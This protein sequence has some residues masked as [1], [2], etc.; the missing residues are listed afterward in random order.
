ME[1]TSA[2]SFIQRVCH[3]LLASAQN[4][5][6]GWGFHPASESRVEPASWALLGL[7]NSHSFQ[8]KEE[9]IARGLRFIRSTQLPDGSWPSTPG[10]KAG[11]WVTS[12]ACWALS[13]D[14]SAADPAAAGLNW[15]CNDWPRDSSRWSRLLRRLSPGRERLPHNDSYRGWG[16]TTRTSSWVEPTSFAL[17]ALRSAA[18]GRLPNRA[19]RRRL[20]AEALLHDRMCRGG[21][22]NCGNSMIYGVPGEP[23]VIPTVW[24]LLALVEYPQRTENVQSLNWLESG[25]ENIHG[26]GSLAL[27]QTC[28]ESYGRQ[29]PASAPQLRDFYNNNEFLQS[30]PVVAWAC[31]AL[32]RRSDW[33]GKPSP[34]NPQ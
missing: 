31:L 34:V 20:L 4:Q 10:E 1:A 16:W 7:L 18:A 23:L 11:S 28:L 25:L 29:W 8:G 33:L 6:G 30:I 21:G 17:I 14:G 15:L 5:D 12:L 19:Q 9:M 32:E 2:A 13:F 26:P 22:W 3:P 24:A 27:A